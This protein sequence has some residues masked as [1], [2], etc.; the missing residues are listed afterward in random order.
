MNTSQIKT[1][2]EDI[3]DISEQVGVMQLE[4]RFNG[5]SHHDVVAEHGLRSI[6]HGKEQELLSIMSKMI[7]DKPKPIPPTGRIVK[8]IQ[9]IEK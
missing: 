8:E 2:L 7:Y 4:R 9:E 5:Y 6:L 3:I 1:L